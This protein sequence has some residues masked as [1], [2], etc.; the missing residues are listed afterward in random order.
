[1][2]V[3]AARRVVL[4]DAG[5]NTGCLFAAGAAKGLESTPSFLLGAAAAALGAVAGAVGPV[6]T[7]GVGA[8]GGPTLD[9]EQHV[10]E[11]FGFVGPAL[12]SVMM[13][14]RT[15]RKRVCV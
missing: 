9:T 4:L 1:M 7:A 11:F 10:H 15:S 8:D 6:C 5:V 14:Y 2:G 13:F 12:G 3:F